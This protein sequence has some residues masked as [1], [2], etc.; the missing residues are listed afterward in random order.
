MTD[1]ARLYQVRS[2]RG[3]TTYYHTVAATSKG[4]A[5]EK[6]RDAFPD[7]HVF[8]TVETYDLYPGIILECAQE[9]GN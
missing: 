8:M 5:F 3:E 7:R 4:E 2:K 9:E 1:T 6:Y